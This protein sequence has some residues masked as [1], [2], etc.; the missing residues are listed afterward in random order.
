MKTLLRQAA[1]LHSERTAYIV[2]DDSITY[3]E[4]WHEAEN[5]ADCLC[6]QG[7][8]A[9]VLYG[10]KSIHMLTAMLACV[11]SG[12][13]YVPVAKKTPHKRLCDIIRASRAD[14]LL[15]DNVALEKLPN[16][17]TSCDIG[18]LS[19]FGAYPKKEQNGE[20]AYI[21]FT[22]G[23]TGE[24]KGV[25]ITYSNLK[26]FT[27]WISTV[28][29][30]SE[31]HAAAVLDQASFSFDLSVAD[32]YYALPNGHTL[33]SLTS[34]EL[35]YVADVLSKRRVNVCVSTP[36]FVKLCMTDPD[37]NEKALPSLRCVYL[38]GETL[39]TKTVH[40][41][42]E[43][44]P[45]LDVINAYG[46]TEATSAV[47]AALIRPEMLEKAY[48]PVGEV[49]KHA[50]YVD[51]IGDEIVIGG[52][53]VSPGY[54]N[55]ERGGFFDEDGR[56]MY[57]TGDVGRIEDGYLY[58]FGRRDRQIKYKGYRIE[59]S[60]IEQ[61]IVRLDGVRECAVVPVRSADGTVRYLAAYVTG[62]ITSD[63]RE[64]LSGLL[65]EYMLPKLVRAV[66]SLPMTANGK[67]DRGKIEN[68]YFKDT[69]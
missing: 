58:C 14:L 60:D 55:G 41:L 12:R 37:F 19:R 27:K 6:R 29:P 53:S 42:W 54:L 7:S 61:N 67:T 5:A 52:E 64:R 13:A 11:I 45:S 34:N 22:S 68:G 15:T 10:G 28:Y 63:I 9:V 1:L 51:V 2:D 23:T 25:P 26:S 8:G 36:T 4:L 31:L 3:G 24:P 39:D 20:I 43:R 50:T 66:D 35:S 30:L 21:I 32:V 38:C 56:H 33:V 44:F 16:G 59:L 40:R 49:G 18:E 46:P 62:D 47:S 48:L 57:R 17:V 69:L 65:P